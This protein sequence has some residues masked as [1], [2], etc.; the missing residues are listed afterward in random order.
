[1]P[2][3]NY[4]PDIW[5]PRNLRVKLTPKAGPNADKPF[6]VR[7][8]KGAKLEEGVK[9]T[10]LKALG[11]APLAVNVGAA[12]P[13][14]SLPITDPS[15]GWKFGRWLAPKG[16]GLSPYDVP[17]TIE[18]ILTK[19]GKTTVKFEITGAK[20][21]KGFA[22]LDAGDSEIANELSGMAT[23]ILLDGESVFGDEENRS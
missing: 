11:L 10:V 13:K 19:P 5:A 23:D 12:E 1:M 8:K 7:S 14:W 20:G 21:E 18:Y 17:F 15:D 4:H 3:H 2:G 6:P 16:S 9:L 22:N